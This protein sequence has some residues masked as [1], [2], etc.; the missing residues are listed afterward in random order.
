MTAPRLELTSQHQKVSRLPTE[1]PG[2]PA[3]LHMITHAAGM[4]TCTYIQKLF[5]CNKNGILAVYYY[6]TLLLYPYM[7]GT[8]TC[9]LFIPILGWVVQ[10]FGCYLSPRIRKT[11]WSRLRWPLIANLRPPK[12]AKKTELYF[13]RGF[14]WLASVCI[15]YSVRI[16]T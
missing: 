9:V 7:K 6:G 13:C 16:Q 8:N 11:F 10:N 5:L 2:R 3:Y 12:E 14:H 15:E 1:P 4:R